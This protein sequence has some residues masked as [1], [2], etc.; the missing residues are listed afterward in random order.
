MVLANVMV[1]R[2][3]KQP[4]NNF[5]TS[6]YSFI[7]YSTVYRYWLYSPETP[8]TLSKSKKPISLPANST[9]TV[10]FK[11]ETLISDFPCRSR[12]SQFIILPPYQGEGHGGNF[13]SALYAY[14]LASPKTQEITVE[15]PNE[16]FDDLRDLN[17][18]AHLR[19]IKSFT[20]LRLNTSVSISK[21]GK[22]PTAQLVDTEILEKIRT[23]NKIAPRQFYRLVEMQLLSTIPPAYRQSSLLTAQ[24][25][26]VPPEEKKLKEHEY[27]LW[28]LFVKQRL[29]K[30]NK[31]QL[32]QVD[33]AE[34]VDKL[35]QALGSVEGDY[36][37]LLRSADQRAK[38]SGQ[39]TSNGEAGQGKGKRKADDNEKLARESGQTASKKPKTD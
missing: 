18:L 11:P 33:R 24:R 35:E 1:I 31:D 34:R 16:S 25:S 8:T 10:P 13:Y 30:H 28:R 3:E 14:L 38:S 15:D 19:T 12:I 22:V 4:R 9:F 27:R 6:S 39:E 29:Y 32:M 17:D 21:K 5:D 20:N 26:M 7:G 23:E 2:F 37:R 36:S